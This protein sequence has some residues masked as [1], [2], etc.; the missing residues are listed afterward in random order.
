MHYVYQESRIWEGSTPHKADPNGAVKR[1]KAKSEERAR[2]GLGKP[3][4]G[5]SWVLVDTSAS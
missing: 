2:K 1:V 5:R 4:T 3:S